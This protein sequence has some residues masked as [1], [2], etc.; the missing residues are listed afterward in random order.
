MKSIT[1][2]GTKREIVGKK[3]TKALRNADQVPCVVYGGDA[4]LH[5][6]APELSFKSLVYTPEAHTVVLDID[7]QSV[8]AI[9]QDIQYHP[10]TDRIL[11]IDFYQL[12]E[13]KEV[14]MDIPVLLT[15]RSEGVS[16]GGSLRNNMRKLTVKALPANLPDN[17]TVDI[18]PL[19][20]GD[21]VYVASLKSDKFEILHPD[22]AVIVAVRTSRAA[23]AIE[24]VVVEGEG[25]QAEGEEA[26]AE[27]K[28]EGEAK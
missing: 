2:Q 20:I 9:L 22:N 11:H 16:L 7:G 24:E 1:I 28:K 14:T 18:T 4:P 25:T 21:K 12:H 26:E 3:A 27:E 19:K 13:D 10:V 15:G 23:M 6:T 5:F 8:N 17:V